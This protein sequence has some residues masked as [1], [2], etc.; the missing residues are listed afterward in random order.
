[1]M[2]IIRQIQILRTK[3]N[4]HNIRYYVHDDPIISDSEYDKL[5]RELTVLENSHPEFI[6]PDS[7]T[8]RIGA[9]PLDNFQKPAI[10]HLMSFN[11]KGI[12]I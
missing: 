5:M 10:I 11:Q 8:Q 1:M 4:R 12:I 6:I 2:E 9:E 3:I 7:P